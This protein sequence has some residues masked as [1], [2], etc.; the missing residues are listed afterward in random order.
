[1]IKC[2]RVKKSEGFT[3]IEVIAVLVILGILAAVAVPKFMDLQEEARKKAIEGAFAAGGSQLAM[4][5]A[6]DLLEG[7]A[8]A[9]SWEYDGT[10]VV[11]GDFTADLT[12]ACG[13]EASSVEI[14]D[15]P[16][17]VDELTDKTRTFTICETAPQP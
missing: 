1:M 9:N 8:T 14:T 13:S 11:L 17:W 16:D 5:Y 12:G 3:L 10:G 4:Q 7:D 2:R 15:G 6:T